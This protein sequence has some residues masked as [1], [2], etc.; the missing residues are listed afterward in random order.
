[1][2]PSQVSQDKLTPLWTHFV[3]TSHISLTYSSKEP[4]SIS[5]KGTTSPSPPIKT[6]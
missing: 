4:V 3:T 6:V 2:D 1:M 5:N